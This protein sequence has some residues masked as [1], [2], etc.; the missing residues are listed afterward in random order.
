MTV[1]KWRAVYDDGTFLEEDY[2]PGGAYAAIERHKLVR[3]ELFPDE[4]ALEPFWSVDVPRG[5]RLVWRM[6]TARTPGSGDRVLGLVAIESEDRRDVD[7]WVLEPVGNQVLVSR[8][9]RYTLAPLD[10]PELLDHEVA[11]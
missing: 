1:A 11:A 8:H 2:R 4:R 10:A 5:S 9:A 7:L 6:R 3:F